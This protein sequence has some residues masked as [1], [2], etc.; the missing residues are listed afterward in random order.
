MKQ[1]Q[2]NV[3]K[4]WID[5]EYYITSNKLEVE[6]TPDH[7]NVLLPLIEQ[8]TKEYTKLPGIFGFSLLKGIKVI[9]PS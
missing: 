5:Q 6:T 7:F 9:T 2:K 4:F 1:Q 3:G 8:A